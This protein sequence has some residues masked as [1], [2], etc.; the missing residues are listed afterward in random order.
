MPED[1][2]SSQNPLEEDYVEQIKKLKATTVSKEVFEKLT[3]EN[4]KLLEALVDGKEIEAGNTAEALTKADYVKVLNN[5][6]VSNLEYC[7][8]ALGVRNLVLAEK[9]IDVFMPNGAS[10]T[11]EDQEKAQAV[12]DAIQECID[13]ADGDSALF[14]QEL[15]R[16]TVDYIAKK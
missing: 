13:Y 2:T 10:A 14:T 1:Q 6:D 8:A 9:G 3:A 11:A 16:K 15:Q 7:K 4:K 12:A 5:P